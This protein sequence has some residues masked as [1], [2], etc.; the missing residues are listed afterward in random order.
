MAPKKSI[1]FK[2]VEIAIFL[3]AIAPNH[4]LIQFITMPTKATITASLF[5]TL[6][7]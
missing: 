4:S 7:K 1:K 2:I 6:K 5:A 3:T